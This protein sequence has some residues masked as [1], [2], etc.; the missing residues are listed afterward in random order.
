MPTGMLI[1]CDDSRVNWNGAT[2]VTLPAG[3]EPDPLVRALEEKYR[4]SRFDIE[5]RDPAPAGHYDIQLRSPDGGES[6]L[7]GEGF[8]PNTIRIA[9]GSECF[10]WPEGE[11]IGGEF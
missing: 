4:D 7:I 1:R 8:D 10:P 6:Y 11:Y 5:V 3:T 2:T 9:S